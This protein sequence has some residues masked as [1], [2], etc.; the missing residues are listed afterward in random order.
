MKGPIMVKPKIDLP[1]ESIQRLKMYANLFRDGFAE[2]VVCRY[3]AP[4]LKD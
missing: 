3:L 2:M 4:M 1:K